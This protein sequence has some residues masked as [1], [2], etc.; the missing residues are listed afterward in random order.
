[1]SEIRCSDLTHEDVAKVL[2][3]CPETGQLRWKVTDRVKR[4]GSLAGSRNVTGYINVKLFGR[5]YKAHRLA[6]L[7]IY[8]SWPVAQVDHINRIRDDNRAANLRA[9]TPYEN[10][11]NRA[12]VR[13]DGS[14]VGVT[15]HVSGNAWQAEISANGRSHYL[16]LFK[17]R[18]MAAAAYRE[19]KARLHRPAS[20]GHLRRVTLDILA[21]GER[22]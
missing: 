16:G 1:M 22:E 19:A 4:A 3:Y 8:G 13:P 5:T 10:A 15:W 11:Q 21:M 9:A 7:L 14:P 2:D 17:T 20:E 12:T 6:W 18:E